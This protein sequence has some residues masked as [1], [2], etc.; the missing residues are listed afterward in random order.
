VRRLQIEDRGLCGI[1]RLT[2]AL[3]LAIGL[4][5]LSLQLEL[6]FLLLGQDVL[7][8]LLE[9]LLHLLHLGGDQDLHLLL[10]LAHL[11]LEAAHGHLLVLELSA[12]ALKLLELLLELL[13]LE[14]ESRDLL[15][16]ASF[17][18]STTTNQRLTRT[19]KNER[20][21]RTLATS[22]ATA[23]SGSSANSATIARK[24]DSLAMLRCVRLSTSFWYERSSTPRF[25]ILSSGE[26]F[27]NSTSEW[28][29]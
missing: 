20:A 9:L 23:G 13:V 14:F 16:V 6:A 26:C 11:L 22:R 10:V 24:A 7:L 27:W 18:L 12:L 17:E 21:R 4:L 2:S 29:H 15:R 25:L 3:G 19:A 5:Q 28:Q 1:A 8:D